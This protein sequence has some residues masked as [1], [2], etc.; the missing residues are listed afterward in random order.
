MTVSEDLHGSALSEGEEGARTVSLTTL[1]NECE[2]RRLKPPFAIKMDTHGV[3]L[4]ILSGASNMLGS[5]EL[6][7][8]EAYNFCLSERS[9]RFHELCACMERMGFRVADLVDLV[10]RPTDQVLWQMDLFFRPHASID[11]KSDSYGS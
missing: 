8:I 9:V 7:I 3:E 1:D 5:T 11:F 2:S 10:W 6:V 4:D